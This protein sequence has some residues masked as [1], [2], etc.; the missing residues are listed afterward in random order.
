M[1]EFLFRSKDHTGLIDRI[2][3]ER[4]GFIF[5]D[6]AHLLFDWVSSRPTFSEI[7]KLKEKFSCP[8]LALSATLKQEYLA[9]MSAR[10]LRYPVVIKGSINRT[11]SA[12]SSEKECLKENVDP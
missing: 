10:I 9:E 8:V 6:E 11:L 1:P 12:Y 7:E 3:S 5:I 2:E 4:L